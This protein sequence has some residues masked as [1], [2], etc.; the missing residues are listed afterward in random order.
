MGRIFLR[1]ASCLLFFFMLVLFASCGSSKDII[2]F[3]KAESEY[4]ATKDASKY[5]VHITNNDNLLITVTS[6][7][8]QATEIFNILKLDR[9]VSDN[10]L[11]WQG[12]LVDQSGNINFPLI[13]QIH[14]GGLTKAQAEKILQDKISSYIEDPVVNIRFM[15]YKVTV[16]GEVTRPGAYTIDDE[17]LT[18]VQSLGLAGDLTIYGNRHD[19]MVCREV[20][21][22]KK[23]YR[24]DITSPDIFNSPVYYLQQNDIV[25]VEPNKA[26]VRNSTN[27]IQNFSLG[28]SV[29][30]LLLTVALFFKN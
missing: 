6:K 7:N 26:K 28:I 2:Y 17:K 14:L 16:L 4:N 24:V 27:Y 12:Y 10:V 29:I 25:Y 15:N 23:F 9:S 8:P 20:A 3:Q 18:I 11:K 22:Q 5:E 19:I 1:L 21:G 30:S 13:G